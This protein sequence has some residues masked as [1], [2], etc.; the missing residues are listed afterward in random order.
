[1]KLEEILETMEFDA[2]VDNTALDRESLN[3]PKLHSKWLKIYA[4]EKR[5]LGRLKGQLATLV[6]QKY[7][8]YSGKAP[9][10]VYKE[11]PF[12]LKLLK[13]DVEKYI[14]ADEDVQRIAQGIDIQEEKIYVISEFI[15]GINQR[16][17]NIKN[18]IEY[19]RWTSGG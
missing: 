5:L 3:I 19:L 4:E 11:K 14:E 17:F 13:S 2:V 7:E 18:A 1:M 15:R 9:A 10:E 6:Q 16:S 12:H 8:Y